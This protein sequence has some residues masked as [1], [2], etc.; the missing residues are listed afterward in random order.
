MRGWGK[1]VAEGIGSLRNCRRL[2]NGRCLFSALSRK[3]V[4]SPEGGGQRG[5]GMPTAPHPSP[6]STC[7]ALSNQIHCADTL[8][9]APFIMG[10]LIRKLRR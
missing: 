3:P 6:P 7:S 8:P 2:R 10:T 5:G 9:D 4:C 1:G